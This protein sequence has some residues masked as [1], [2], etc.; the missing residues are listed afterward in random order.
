MKFTKKIFLSLFTNFNFTKLKYLF[1]IIFF[2]PILITLLLLKPIFLIRIGN[3]GGLRIGDAYRSE[4]ILSKLSLRKKENRRAFN[5]WTTDRVVCNKQL[6]IMW[7]RNFFIIHKLIIFYELLNL[8]SKYFN[9]FKSHLLVVNTGTDN[10][11]LLDK[12]KNKLKLI[13]DEI[14]KGA[15]ILEKFG[16]PKD[17]KIVCL[18]VRDESYLSKTYPNIDWSYH[19]FRNSNIKNYILP[20][21]N[22]LK[23]NYYV[24][25]MG[26]EAKEKVKI[27]HK[28]F[29][30]YPFHSME[31]NFMDFYMGYR[32]EFW[33]TTGTGIDGVSK[34]YRKP[35]L[36]ID[37]VPVAHFP[38][39][40]KQVTIPK[41]HLNLKN[42][43]K[44]SL[45]QIFKLRVENTSNTK[46]FK[47]KN[48]AVIESTSREI[49]SY[50]K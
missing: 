43:K 10:E 25:R 37:M 14:I 23:K 50:I 33:I 9:V 40:R 44:M 31:S 17:A 49:N 22:L 39:Y 26:S 1:L 19:S 12:T 4:L 18:T 16:I 8:L 28:R 30:D 11:N 46:E 42:K 45:A 48:I 2:S 3:L 21:K 34:I 24:F 13:K 29:I 36:L 6:L 35:Y 38:D 20:I 32:C 5:I 7:K 47:K 27:H 15:R 41:K